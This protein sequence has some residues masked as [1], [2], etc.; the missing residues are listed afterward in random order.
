MEAILQKVAADKGIDLPNNDE[1]ELVLYYQ[2]GPPKE[3]NRL[4]SPSGFVDAQS[5]SDHSFDDEQIPTALFEDE[6]E[7][8]DLPAPRSHSP[9]DES[10]PLCEA[11]K[12]H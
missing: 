10:P 1:L 9:P 7:E 6:G 5:E 4:P 2:F 12:D 8:P 3:E 11:R